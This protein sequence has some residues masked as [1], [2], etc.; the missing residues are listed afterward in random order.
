MILVELRGGE[1]KKIL[2]KIEVPQ[3]YLQFKVPVIYA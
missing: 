2:K 3:L 1:E